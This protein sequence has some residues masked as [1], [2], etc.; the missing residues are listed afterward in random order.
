MED[1][2]RIKD[3]KTQ[4]FQVPLSEPLGDAVHGLHTHFELITVT[5][6]LADGSEGTGYTYTGGFGGKAIYQVI[7]H[8]LKPWLIDRDGSQVEGLWDAMGWR[9]HYVGRGGITSFAISAID[10]ALW[11]IRARMIDQPLWKIAGGAD[12][13][14]KAYYGGIDLDFPLE[15]LLSNIRKQLDSGHTAIKIKLGKENLSEDIERVKAVREMIGPDVDFM[16]DAN[17]SW[18]VEKAIKAANELEK[19][20]IFWLEEPTV[21][22]DYC[23][24]AHIAESTSISLAMGENLHTIYEHKQALQQS[25]I[26]FI[27]PDASNVGGIT[28]WLKVANLA[29]AYNVPVCSHG[30]QELHVSLLAAVPHAGYL[31]IHSFPI[32]QYTENPVVVRKGR[33]KAPDISGTGVVFNWSKLESYKINIM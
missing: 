13:S 10:I 2:Y 32:D 15:K 6:I 12:S 28:G 14:C 31:E 4:Y 27:Q 33:A 26:R 11:D 24:M 1:R 20:N 29:E 3:L 21:P 22:D 30:M 8:D 16:V 25:K 17:M 7:E 19:F 5:V 9:I 23:G 18:T